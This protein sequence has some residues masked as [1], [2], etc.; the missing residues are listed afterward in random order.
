MR[1]HQTGV[2]FIGWLFLLAPLA[3]LGYAA[4]RVVPAYNNYA[5][6]SRALD[7]LAKEQADGSDLT[8]P[9]LKDYLSRRFVTESIDQPSIE[10]L[11]F[12]REQGGW[13]IEADYE[14]VTPLFF[15]ISLL[16]NFNK[17]VTLGVK[18]AAQ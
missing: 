4:M 12:T 6:V 16:L 8:L 15:N 13:R 7:G 14:I 2:T 9:E 1:R 17:T 10:E 3:V 18:G 5:G 11:A